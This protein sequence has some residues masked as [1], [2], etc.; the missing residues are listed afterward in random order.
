M[1]DQ[2]TSRHP[3][4]TS[5]SHLV[6][7]VVCSHSAFFFSSYSKA[8]PLRYGSLSK[9][10]LTD[11]EKHKITKN[12]APR[13]KSLDGRSKTGY[14]EG[15]SSLGVLRAKGKHQE[16]ARTELSETEIDDKPSKIILRFHKREIT[17]PP[18]LIPEDETTAMKFSST[19]NE[20]L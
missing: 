4:S 12:R 3:I 18:V 19:K 13:Y 14:C 5:T 9:I 8:K 17:S 6:S 11:M 20:D 10:A 16:S 2:R 7:K 1:N 15:P